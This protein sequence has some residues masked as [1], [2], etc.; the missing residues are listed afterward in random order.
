MKNILVLILVFLFCQVPQHSFAQTPTSDFEQAKKSA[1]AQDY[2]SAITAMKGLI[3][4]HPHNIEYQIFLARVYSWNQSFEEAIDILEPLVKKKVR[5]ALEVMI[6]IQSWSRQYEEVIKYAKLADSL[7]PDSSFKIQQSKA[8]LSLEE[9]KKAKA[10]IDEI[11]DEEPNNKETRKLLSE[12]L[13]R[14]ERKLLISY[15]NTSFSNP[16]F[17]PWH[18]ASL[19]YK[20][21]LGTIPVLPRI[22]YGQISG[23]EG[24]LIE[25]DAY[26]KIYSKGYLYLNAGVSLEGSAFPDLRGAVEYY[27]TLNPYFSVSLGVKYM[28]FPGNE[29]LL[30]TGQIAYTFNNA[31]RISYRSYLADID[32]SSSLSH[33][34]SIRFP[35]SINE[36]FVQLDLQYGNLPYE[37]YAT[38][39][40]TNLKS[41]RAGV[42]YQFRLTQQILL[43]PIFI[44]E[45]EEYFPEQYRHRF[46]SQILATYRF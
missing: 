8:L 44:Y 24:F 35:E 17:R 15:L 16:G 30:Y 6:Q 7:Y 18:L 11:L 20:T 32:D 2:R 9:N 23:R 27:Q 14:K 33:S 37:Y 1:Y 31:T 12:I 34:L 13:K 41:A 43:Q 4:E 5:E 29:A 39:I 25:L 38:G 28:Q 36:N 45:Y 46:N 10:L 22:Q 42:Q 26:P 21:N 3:E 40:Q 19:G